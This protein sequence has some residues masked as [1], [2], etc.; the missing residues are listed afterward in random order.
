MPTICT[1]KPLPDFMSIYDAVYPQLVFPPAVNIAYPTI[2][3]IP[4]VPGVPN[5]PPFIVPTLPT[6]IFDKFSNLNLEVMQFVQGL[7]DFQLQTTLSLMIK[8]LADFLGGAID[9]FLPTIP[10]TSINLVDLLAGNMEKI[11]REIAEALANI[12]PMAFPMLPV[13]LFNSFSIPNIEAISTLKLILKGYY[14]DVMMIIPG[15]IDSVVGILQLP[16]LPALPTLPTLPDVKAMLLDK[17]LALPNIPKP[18]T[19]P[20]MPPLPPI[21]ATPTMKD[22]PLLL[23]LKGIEIPDLFSMLSF[24][25]FPTL[26][27]PKPLIPTMSNFELE[28]N[29]SLSILFA[30]FLTVPLKK[31]MDFLEGTLGMLGFSFPTICITI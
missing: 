26:S 21:P 29:E 19:V 28:L 1:N 2:P 23:K 12:G 30:D 27:L 18:P 20:G 17:A 22:I 9:S 24:P 11:K 14:K 3:D 13:P 4:P 25:G 5:I 7:Q 6:P 16:G 15:M 8:P 10:N 31:I